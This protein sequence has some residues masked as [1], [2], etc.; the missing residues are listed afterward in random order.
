MICSLSLPELFLGQDGPQAV[1]SGSEDAC[2][3]ALR[4]PKVKV[5]QKDTEGMSALMYAAEMG[6]MQVP[7]LKHFAVDVTYR[8]CLVARW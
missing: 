5:D 8:T 1:K 4:E 6:H 7:C 3:R 2:H